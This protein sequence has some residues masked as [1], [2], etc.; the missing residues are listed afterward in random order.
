MINVFGRLSVAAFGLTYNMMDRTG[1]QY[2]ILSTNWASV[3]WTPNGTVKDKAV[4]DLFKTEDAEGEGPT[5]LD[6]ML[7]QGTGSNRSEKS[8]Q[9]QFGMDYGS[10][11]ILQ[12]GFLW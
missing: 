2:P 8:F 1:I 3:S 12:N 7:E 6:L 11:P 10:T 9:I 4:L 5:P